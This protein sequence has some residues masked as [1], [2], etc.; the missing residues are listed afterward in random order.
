MASYKS[1]EIEEARR[2]KVEEINSF[3]NAKQESILKTS[4]FNGA[5]DVVAG[6]LASGQLKEDEVE[7]K[8]RK[9]SSKLEAMIRE[10]VTGTPF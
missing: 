6:L 9:W 3:Q 10:A 2:R 8:I 7:L 4:A 5:V 1:Q